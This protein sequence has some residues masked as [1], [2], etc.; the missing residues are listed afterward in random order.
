MNANRPCR[1]ASRPSA[2]IPATGRGIQA[3]GVAGCCLLLFLAP[4]KWGTT[5]VRA[6]ENIVTP[7]SGFWE[8]VFMS[9]PNSYGHYAFMA[10]S[11]LTLVWI[12]YAWHT[13]LRAPRL[14]IALLGWAVLACAIALSDRRMPREWTDDPIR[15][16]IM[17]YGVWWLTT[18][19]FLRTT[20]SRLLG[21]FA[22]LTAALI[23]CVTAFDQHAGGFERMRM[24]QAGLHGCTTF[25]EYTN[26]LVGIGDARAMLEIKK[27]LSPRVF[28][29][30]VYPNAL[31]GFL[32]M[33]LPLSLGFAA[34]VRE[35]LPRVFAGLVCAL[36]IVTLALTR[37]KASIVLTCGAVLVYALLGARG[38]VMT[39]RRATT[40]A[41]LAVVLGAGM[42]AWGYGERLPERLRAT[43]GARLD[44]WRA[45]TRMI[46]RRPW[47]GWGTDG[48][49]RNYAIFRRP[50]AEDTKLAHN[51]VL[52]MWTDYGVPGVCGWLLAFGAPLW[53]GMRRILCRHAQ[54]PL[55]I[56]AWCAGVAV[57]LHMAL[58]LDF[59]II[60][61]VAPAL[62]V[63]GCAGVCE[64]D[65][66][67]LPLT[68]N[69][70]QSRG[71][72]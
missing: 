6:A 60:G 51:A 49:T 57:T 17:L 40:T 32:I 19:A 22:V 7:P 27:L 13:K 54:Q 10:L 37:S 58:D 62:F 15:M 41:V 61:I 4:V 68:E 5:Q 66:A 23:T 59:H 24:L 1:A 46:A 30:F 20:A 14:S 35:W 70:T 25:A 56:A 31:G 33:A 16:Q 12:A 9:Y 48:F 42:L 39:W 8:W 55:V 36:S 50:D 45:A 18:T 34:Q 71:D 64:D 28:G 11:V 26:Y 3:L 72:T 2:A 53:A 38:R 52:N 44:Y 21:V 65:F 43:G 69:R 29:T 63:L 67:I 47:L